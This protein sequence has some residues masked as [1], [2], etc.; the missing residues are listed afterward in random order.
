MR[1]LDIV[2]MYCRTRSLEKQLIPVTRFTGIK[3]GMY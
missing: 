2:F 1:Y 3:P